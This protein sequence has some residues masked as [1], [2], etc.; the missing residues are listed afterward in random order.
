[1]ETL[2]KYYC[3]LQEKPNQ[4]KETSGRQRCFPQQDKESLFDRY[5]EDFKKTVKKYG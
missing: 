1:M 2:S 4:S 3:S 5:K